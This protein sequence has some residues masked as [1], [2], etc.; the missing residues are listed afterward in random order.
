MND[1]IRDGW[2]ACPQCGGSSRR[3]LAPN[4]Y[5]CVTERTIRLPTGAHPS[6]V[7]GSAWRDYVQA[8]GFEY[9][10]APLGDLSSTCPS[11]RLFA[12]GVCIVCESTLICGRC[13]GQRC[14]TC[15]LA[16][17]AAEERATLEKQQLARDAQYAPVRGMARTYGEALAREPDARAKALIAVLY[18]LWLTQLFR[19]A[20]IPEMV[21]N[22]GNRWKAKQIPDTVEFASIVQQEL[23][24]NVPEI[25]RSVLH[26]GTAP[27]ITW[28]VNP[29]GLASWLTDRIGPATKRV[30][31]GVGN[32]DSV[33]FG[34][35]GARVT[36]WQLPSG[37]F[38]SG[39]AKLAYHKPR[40]RG[41][42]VLDGQQWLIRNNA[43]HTLAEV[44]ATAGVTVYG[45][46]PVG[47]AS[48]PA[49][50]NPQ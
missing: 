5:Q 40:G 38:L 23:G 29:S 20:S 21:D 7:Q 8:C 50:I 41:R 30:T 39:D 27:V 10:E 49:I 33:L 35:V 31:I 14:S 13:P 2:G 48:S 34:I 12:I 18:R 45:N 17:V 32:Y 46:P 11:H 1:T 26:S 43:G 9:A 3:I 25:G 6:G 42:G 44:L 22:E 19:H 36:C 28:T 24:G 15:H 37:T 47:W 16:A 4:H